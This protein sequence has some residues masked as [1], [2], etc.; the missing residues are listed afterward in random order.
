MNRKGN[1]GEFFPKNRFGKSN[2]AGGNNANPRGVWGERPGK[3]PGQI[4]PA[5]V[6]TARHNAQGKRRLTDHQ[7]SAVDAKR[8]VREYIFRGGDAAGSNA[9]KNKLKGSVNGGLEPL[10]VAFA[11]GA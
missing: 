10:S 8:V 2:R 6:S 7:Y 3:G 1:R 4:N 5:A 9:A 11:V